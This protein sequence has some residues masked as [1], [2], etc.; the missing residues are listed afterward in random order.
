MLQEEV[1]ANTQL[2]EEEEDS[3]EYDSEIYQSEVFDPLLEDKQYLVTMIVT[4]F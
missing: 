3:S 2:K 1:A 4:H